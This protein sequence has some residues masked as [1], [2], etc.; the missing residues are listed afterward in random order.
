MSCLPDLEQMYLIPLTVLVAP[1]LLHP[2]ADVAAARPS[3]A[4]GAISKHATTND[5]LERGT[6]QFRVT[7]YHDTPDNEISSSGSNAG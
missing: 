1:I 4:K 2:A 5:H 6:P 3:A 7:R